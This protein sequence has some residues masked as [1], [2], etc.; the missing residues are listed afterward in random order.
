M[1]SICIKGPRSW[2]QR[3]SLVRVTRLLSMNWVPLGMERP[4][5]Q[6]NE[7][8]HSRASTETIKALSV[9]LK[10]RVNM[11]DYLI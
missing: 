1:P 11:N 2:K 7:A 8:S 3:G 9:N 4:G 6:H 5:K 10:N